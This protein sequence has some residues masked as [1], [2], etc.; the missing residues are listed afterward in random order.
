MSEHPKF[1]P[2]DTVY[3]Q[4]G[5]PT[6]SSRE[7]TE[8]E[9]N[10]FAF[11]VNKSKKEPAKEMP[12][13]LIQ[14]ELAA[15]KAKSEE[16]FARAVAE[17]NAAYAK[18]EKVRGGIDKMPGAGNSGEAWVSS[19]KSRMYGLE[20][21]KSEEESIDKTAI[22]ERPQPPKKSWLGKLLGK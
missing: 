14:D 15:R 21:L 10:E 11:G 20:G 2:A 12:D 3:G 1:I 7:M 6:A 18:L 4:G 17:G 9:K 5:E 8:D 13:F 22:V 16:V 19:M